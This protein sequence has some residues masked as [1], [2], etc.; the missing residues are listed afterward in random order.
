MFY[1]MLLHLI[2]TSFLK[3]DMGSWFHENDC[4]IRIHVHME[5][6]TSA[7]SFEAEVNSLD[8]FRCQRNKLFR[9]FASLSHDTLSIISFE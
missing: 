4:E 5:G 6:F 9:Q 7:L 2:C 8:S 3:N 1:A